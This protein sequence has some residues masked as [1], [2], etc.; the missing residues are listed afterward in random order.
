MRSPIPPPAKA[1]EG[2]S[3]EGFMNSKKYVPRLITVALLLILTGCTKGTSTPEKEKK[4]ETEKKAETPTE[5]TGGAT[6]KPGGA[7]ELTGDAKKN[8]E[9]RT[10]PATLRSLQATQD[11]PG[12]IEIAANRSIKVTPSAPGKIISLLVKPGDKVQLGQV[13]ATLDS[14]EVAQGHAATQQAEAS[15]AQASASLQTAQAEA[16]QADAGVKV[17]EAGI[18]QAEERVKSARQALARQ[19][20]LATAGAFA[21]APL[22]TAQSELAE[23]QSELLKS[24]TELQGHLTVLQRAERLF[25]A[26]VVSR[27]ELE[28]AQLEQRQ[29]EASVDKAKR[30]VVNAKLTLER[31][32]KIA[33]AGLLNAR[34]VQTA[35][36][37][38]RDTEADLRKA[39]SERNQSVEAV[40][41]AERGVSAAQTMLVG[42][43]AALRASRTSLSALEGSSGVLGQS[44][45]VVIKAPLTGI[46]AERS[47]TQGEA[48]ERTTVLFTLQNETVVQVTAQVPEAQIG[49]VRTGQTATITVA[50]FPKTRFIGTVQSVG[51]Q[52]D[53]KTRALPVRLLVSNPAGKLKPHMFARVALGLGESRRVLA[54]PE[55][56]LTEIDGKP[57]LFVE[58]NGKYEKRELTLGDRSGG[59]VEVKSGVKAGEE[60]V[61]E[62]AFV[63]KSETK[64]SEL[65]GDE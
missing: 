22:Q 8:A 12:I 29:D 37:S 30:R 27:A 3:L 10:E 43:Q 59:F 7:I 57:S 28:Q 19:K 62:A 53:E 42:A 51:S 25:K 9:I 21:Q 13:L 44:G 31:E 47:V 14:F 41:K 23:A 36:A 65:K 24:Q 48:V 20:E 11:V 15:I 17:A 63:L 35:E 32:Q 33:S 18:G 39:R 61:V 49:L 56:A 1:V 2:V 40:R 60:V 16:R 4:P 38:L 54:V 34:E 64:K 26:E 50:A 45:R 6:E 55:S 5:K 58:E 46:V 52:V